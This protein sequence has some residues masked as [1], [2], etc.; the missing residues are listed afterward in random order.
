MW[1]LFMPVITKVIDSILPDPKASA[2]AKLK[3]LELQQAGE[4]AALDADLK[5]ALGQMAINQEE[6]K[7]TNW[8]VAGWRPGVGWICALAF[9]YAAVFEPLLRFTAKVWFGYAGDFPVID[10]TLTMQVL[11]AILGIGGLRTFEKHKE[12][13]HKR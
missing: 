13:E 4:L 7:S 10:T 5:V 3:L 2:D 6:A 1:Q 8:F 9:G 12:V 11:F